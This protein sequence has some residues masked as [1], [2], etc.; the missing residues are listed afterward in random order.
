MNTR[1]VAAM[2]GMG[3]VIGLL[4]GLLIGSL[5][6]RPDAAPIAQTPATPAV[7]SHAKAVAVE[8]V[9]P[10]AADAE[11]PLPRPDGKPLLQLADRIC[12][13]DTNAVAELI[14]ATD[15]LYEGINF[16]RDTRRVMDNLVVVTAAFDIIAQQ[17]GQSNPA[18]MAALQQC[19]ASPTHVR[20]FAP[21]ALGKAAAAGNTEALDMLL[22]YDQFGIL[23][24]SA[25]GALVKPASDGNA[26]AIAFL[27][28][29]L[30]DPQAQA[31][32][33]EASSGLRAPAAAGNAVAA[34]AIKRYSA[35][36]QKQQ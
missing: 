33:H 25:V 21:Y 13:G 8:S 32:W 3:V 7:P 35:R 9:D 12:Q 1:I 19:V 5:V 26:E 18:A 24:S 34:E 36:S 16:Q 23:E 30:D 15:K 11:P 31:L 29:V 22:H 17:A 4:T 6:F 28:R 10:P 20:G 2:V 27:S 14:A